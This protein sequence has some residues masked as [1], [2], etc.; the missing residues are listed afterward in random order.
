MARDLNVSVLGGRLVREPEL[1]ETTTGKKYLQF[2]VAS[3]DDY[4]DTKKTNW[5]QCKAW[6]PVADKLIAK[7]L[8]KGDWAIFEG[9][10][11]TEEWEKDGQ[12]YSKQLML[13]ERVQF[14]G[15]NKRSSDSKGETFTPAVE[16]DY[17]SYD[18]YDPDE[19]F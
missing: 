19:E 18:E 13:V 3:S 8:H 5:V 9:K 14:G 16:Q 15:S 2:T 7:F 4:G 6:S 11:V 12:R 17:E 1:K 10:Q